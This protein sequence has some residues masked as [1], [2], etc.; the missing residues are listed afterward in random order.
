MD[1]KVL[2]DKKNWEKLFFVYRHNKRNTHLESQFGGG[3]SRY[4]VSITHI[5]CARNGRNS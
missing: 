3:K 4:T 2:I 5:V 1:I